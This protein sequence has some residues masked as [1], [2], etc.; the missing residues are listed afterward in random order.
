MRTPLHKAVAERHI[1]TVKALLEAGANTSIKD[2]LGKTPLDLVALSPPAP[3]NKS[4]STE[5]KVSVGRGCTE[6]D[7]IRTLLLQFEVQAGHGEGEEGKSLKVLA[8]QSPAQ[9]DGKDLAAV[10]PGNADSIYIPSQALL[11]EQPL[12]SISLSSK[13]AEGK[14]HNEEEDSPVPVGREGSGGELG[15]VVEKEVTNECQSVTAG[16]CTAR[17]LDRSTTLKGEP[18]PESMAESSSGQDTVRE[19]APPPATTTEA[20]LDPP[21]G[22]VGEGRDKGMLGAGMRS[23]LVCRECGDRKMVMARSACCK[24]LVCKQCL[25]RSGVVRGGQ[26]RRCK[27]GYT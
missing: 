10:E 27:G 5:V 1:N 15:V 24:A 20:I 3:S 12:T 19:V 17:M 6:Q 18:V 21:N 25:W 4:G 22:A 9:R 11:L 13:E 23:G 7:E 26:C 16:I 14:R 8:I 2:A